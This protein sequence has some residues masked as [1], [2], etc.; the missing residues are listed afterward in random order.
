[1]FLDIFRIDT[2]LRLP[3]FQVRRRR[4]TDL[5]QLL[6][7]LNWKK[8]KLK[9]CFFNYKILYLD[10]VVTFLGQFYFFQYTSLVKKAGRDKENLLIIF[11]KMGS[12]KFQRENSI[13]LVL[14]MSLPDVVFELINVGKLQVALVTG[15]DGE[16]RGE[17]R[18]IGQLPTFF[19]RRLQKRFNCILYKSNWLRI[20]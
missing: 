20:F 15:Q 5:L 14:S 12:S 1:M 19:R 10:S 18:R 3:S 11:V 4:P 16:C 13:K 7:D 6:C 17:V 9:K 8:M 2:F